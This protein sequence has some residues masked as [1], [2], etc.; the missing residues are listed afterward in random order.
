MATLREKLR[1]EVKFPRR[2][3][4]SRVHVERKTSKFLESRRKLVKAQRLERGEV[5]VFPPMASGVHRK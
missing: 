4:H 2:G 3:V 5:K 1:G